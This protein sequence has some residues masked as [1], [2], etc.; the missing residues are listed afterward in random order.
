MSSE[1]LRIVAGNEFG[2]NAILLEKAIHSFLSAAASPRSSR[3]AGCSLTESG[4]CPFAR[5]A[6]L[7]GEFSKLPRAL[8][9]W[10]GALRKRRHYSQHSQLLTENIVKLA[11]QELAFQL[12]ASMSCVNACSSC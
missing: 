1:R 8:G 5:A 11:G 4:G 7:P 6:E 12:W 10:M 2:G 3:I 9:G